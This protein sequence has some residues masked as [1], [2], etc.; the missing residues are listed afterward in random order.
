MEATSQAYRLKETS[1]NAG[2]HPESP[3]PHTE[4]QKDMKF[5]LLV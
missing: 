1:I 4:S 5:L 2:D 3:I